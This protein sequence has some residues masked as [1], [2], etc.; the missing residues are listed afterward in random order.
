M[1]APHAPASNGIV[2]N[3]GGEVWPHPDPVGEK[4]ATFR[5]KPTIATRGPPRSRRSACS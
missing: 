3:R 2:T 5:H 4:E 1:V